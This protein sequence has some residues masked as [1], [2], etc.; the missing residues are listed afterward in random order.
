MPKTPIDADRAAAIS[1]KA[2]AFLAE[3][4]GRLA[5]FLNLTGVEPHAL[6]S[7][8]VEPQFQAAILE[9]VM[10]DENLLLEFCA[11]T[12]L[13]PALPAEALRVLTLQT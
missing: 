3:D 6:R 10:G 2:L 12:E 5:R 9:H 7:Q 11:T 8:A 13:E 1:F 4:Q